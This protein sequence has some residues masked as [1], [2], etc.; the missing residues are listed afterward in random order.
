MKR[1]R[2][3]FDD[4][5]EEEDELAS[6][7]SGEELRKRLHGAASWNLRA[8]ESRIDIQDRDELTDRDKEWT[9]L[10]GTIM[11]RVFDPGSKR[12]VNIRAH[13]EEEDYGPSFRNEEFRRYDIV[14]SDPRVAW[15]RLL[16]GCTHQDVEEMFDRGSLHNQ[17]VYAEELREW[18]KI[19]RERLM[20]GSAE[21]KMQLDIVEAKRE[22]LQYELSTLEWS[23]RFLDGLSKEMTFLLN[24]ML[25]TA[26][27]FTSLPLCRVLGEQYAVA[28]ELFNAL[29]SANEKNDIVIG[30][31]L[32]KRFDTSF[33]FRI[34]K[35]LLADTFLDRAIVMKREHAQWTYIQFQH[36]VLLLYKYLY[37]RD[38]YKPELLW[39]HKGAFNSDGFNETME[40][41]ATT[42]QQ[43]IYETTQNLF[44]LYRKCQSMHLY[45]TAFEGVE[46]GGRL[47]DGSE[48]SKTF[49]GADDIDY[50]YQKKTLDEKLE[51]ARENQRAT[52]NKVKQAELQ[53]E[54][55]K[56]FEELGK[57]TSRR[58]T[59]FNSLLNALKTPLTPEAFQELFKKAEGHFEN[60]PVLSIIHRLLRTD[61]GPFKGVKTWFKS[62]TRGAATTSQFT[63]NPPK[64]LLDKERIYMVVANVA[65]LLEVVTTHVALTGGAGGVFDWTPYQLT[66]DG[67]R[68]VIA[69]HFF[70]PMTTFKKTKDGE[71]TLTIPQSPFGRIQDFDELNGLRN[72]K[73]A[74]T[75][76]FRFNLPGRGEAW[77]RDFIDKC[78]QWKTTFDD[79]GLAD[80]PGQ[81]REIS[82]GINELYRFHETKL[83]EAAF[84][85]ETELD[86]YNVVF[87]KK[88]FT[89]SWSFDPKNLQ[90]LTYVKEVVTPLA[91]ISTALH[92]PLLAGCMTV[93]SFF[94]Q[95]ER[96]VTL[97]D[98][99]A[100]QG[101]LA[102]Y[103]KFVLLSKT[104]RKNATLS[105]T[106]EFLNALDGLMP[107]IRLRKLGAEIDEYVAATRKYRTVE[108]LSLNWHRSL[109]ILL[110]V[111]AWADRV[112]P[113]E[114]AKMD[115]E[116]AKVEQVINDAQ[117]ELYR[118]AMGGETSVKTQR[119]KVKELYAPSAEWQMRPEF[120]GRIILAP[121]VVLALDRALSLIREYVPSLHNATLDALMLCDMESGLPGAFAEFV[122]ALMNK[123][124][125]TWPQT[126]NKDLQYSLAPKLCQDG[127]NALQ[128]YTVRA[129]PGGRYEATRPGT[130]ATT[131]STSSLS[132]VSIFFM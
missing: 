122:G 20:V 30:I 79:K 109:E 41:E 87:F 45:F 2:R 88:G 123:T 44:F 8:G 66:R 95:N 12:F 31:P 6:V 84:T 99:H 74:L 53:H 129:L 97:F 106:T 48:P 128:G 61:E 24:P 114:K 36:F 43:V 13:K 86:F 22:S 127:L 7:V 77:K 16:A 42:L 52:N 111:M 113:N 54:V 82:K 90:T 71:Y 132:S 65:F 27:R 4:E 40:M 5:E 107:G 115:K 60:D 126:Y 102:A 131:F 119:D 56:I 92:E 120:T 39:I 125:L 55:E 110:Y 103:T 51:H 96:I 38:R 25:S 47:I 58:A 63:S 112:Y 98:P 108:A 70:S 121:T 33:G 117:A 50:Y 34:L 94:T 3:A 29:V 89:N 104:E 37:T 93:L 62:Q 59:R 69:M 83:R 101:P 73:Q 26:P 17:Q 124:Q 14:N 49:V 15:M 116:V 18:N 68:F 9:R 67:I 57:L 28:Q 75:F 46:P 118:L 100:F 32:Q 10:D 1:T 91:N 11:Q 72:I 130:L 21:K 85:Q 19:E 76:T 105:D 81:E 78:V 64:D 80:V 35:H 23:S